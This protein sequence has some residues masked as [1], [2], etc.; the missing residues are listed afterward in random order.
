MFHYVYYF[1][2]IWGTLIV[3]SKVRE[4]TSDQLIS[5]GPFHLGLQIDQIANENFV[6]ISAPAFKKRLSQKKINA[7]YSFFD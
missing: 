6:R 5:K 7:I 4:A 2:L 3:L 1:V